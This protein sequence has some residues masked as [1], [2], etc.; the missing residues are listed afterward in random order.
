MDKKNLYMSKE[1][2]VNPFYFNGTVKIREV[3][4]E[5]NSND[6]E[7]YF[8]EFIDGS[9]TTIHLHETEQILIPVYGKGIIGEIDALASRSLMDFEVNDIKLKFLEV[10][11]IVSI[12][13]NILHFHG[14]LPNQ[15][16]SH[17]A[18]RKMFE[19]DCNNNEKI[20]HRTQTRWG[21]DLLANQIGTSDS[22][23][24][25]NKLREISD[26]IQ[27]AINNAIIK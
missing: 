10:G 18:F 19:Y 20:S 27:L 7:L 16:F 6:Q 14:S 12:K 2:K 11:D 25:V 21:Y 5:T 9:I 17:V 26:K 24:I 13:P 23:L 22:A 3:Y 15:N 4:N 1:Q 8:V